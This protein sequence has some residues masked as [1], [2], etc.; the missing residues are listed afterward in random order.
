MNSVV[1][2]VLHGWS[3]WIKAYRFFAERNMHADRMILVRKKLSILNDNGYIDILP[4]EIKENNGY[5]R[6]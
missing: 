4:L 3:R 2:I 1:N 5:S 6:R